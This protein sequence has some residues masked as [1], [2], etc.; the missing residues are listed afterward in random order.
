MGQPSAPLS[1]LV[2]A[3]RSEPH[4]SRLHLLWMRLDLELDQ[5]ASRAVL[6]PPTSAPPNTGQGTAHP[7]PAEPACKRIRRIRNRCTLALI[8]L[9]CLWLIICGFV[10]MAM[11]FRWAL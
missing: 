4:F 3:W 10:L 9:V 6:C 2:I 11:Y 1:A 8:I 5:K 7:I